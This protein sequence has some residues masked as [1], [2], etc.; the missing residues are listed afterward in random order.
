MTVLQRVLNAVYRLKS[1]LDSDDEDRPVIT[2]K[3][4]G[5]ELYS[6]VEGELREFFKHDY[7]E[8]TRVV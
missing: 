5:D 1:K 7:D 8:Q 4:L 2:E 3:Q 6:A